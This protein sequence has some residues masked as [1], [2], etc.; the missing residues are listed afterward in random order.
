MPTAR[1]TDAALERATTRASD[2][3]AL[4]VAA[5]EALDYANETLEAAKPAMFEVSNR[6]FQLQQ[7]WKSLTDPE[8]R[9]LYDKP[10]V[11]IFG[12]CC[13]RDQPDGG[14]TITCG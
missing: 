9:A 8:K 1:A 4:L 3:D 2:A 10:C 13:A 5:A 7:A 11:P 14:K 6:A 12:A